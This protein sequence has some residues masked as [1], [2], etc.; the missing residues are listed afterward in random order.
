[1]VEIAV[2][3]AEVVDG[4]AG[5]VRG[6]GAGSGA[7]PVGGFFALGEVLGEAG[8]E[9][10]G[11]EEVIDVGE[12]EPEAQHEIAAKLVVALADGGEFRVPL[13]P[14][15]GGKGE[16]LEAVGRGIAEILLQRS[17]VF[18]SP[19]FVKCALQNCVI[20]PTISCENLQRFQEDSVGS[21]RGKI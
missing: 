19:D 9:I 5:G 3:G 14:L 20:A 17:T 1:L 4:V 2:E 21:S 18:A 7:V 13:L 10:G 11:V 12:A 15:T 16:V 6:E 8:V